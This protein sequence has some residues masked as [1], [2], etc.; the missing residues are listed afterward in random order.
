MEQLID[1]IVTALGGVLVS[2]LVALAIRALQ[3]I[4]VDLDVKRQ[5]QLEGVAR[6]AVLRV[7]EITKAQARK[8][9]ATWSGPEKLREAVTEVVDRIPRVDALEA[10]RVVQAVLPTVG[11]GAAAA[12]EL[13]KALQTK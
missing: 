3:K 2:V 9:L 12:V 13:G 8:Q 11:I 10:Q 4:G 7:E 1:P 5:E 6:A